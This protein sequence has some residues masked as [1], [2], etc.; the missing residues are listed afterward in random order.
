MT[1]FIVMQLPEVVW[2]TQQI[3]ASPIAHFNVAKFMVAN[4]AKAKYALNRAC[5]LAMMA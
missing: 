4:Y 3:T 2:L 5:R 1:V